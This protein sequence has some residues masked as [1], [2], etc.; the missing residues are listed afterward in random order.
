MANRAMELDSAVKWIANHQPIQVN[1]LITIT[2]RRSAVWRTEDDE[3]VPMFQVGIND[4][5]P[6]Y[7][8]FASQADA[9]YVW[10]FFYYKNL[11]RSR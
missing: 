10:I 5:Y 7:D 9:V 1:Q 6:Q 2:A 3:L 8:M 11:L 4:G